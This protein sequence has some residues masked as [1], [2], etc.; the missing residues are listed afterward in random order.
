MQVPMGEIEVFLNNKSL[1]RNLDYIYK[2]PELYI[3]NKSHLDDPANQP[4]NVHIR[5]TG[6]CK[7][8]FTLNEVNDTGFIEHGVLS[9]DFSYDIRDDKVLRITMNGA[10]VTRDQL[11]FSEFHSGVSITDPLNGIPY[12]IKDVVVPMRGITTADTYSLRDA[13]MEIDKRVSEYLSLKIPQPNRPAVSAI[14]NRYEVYSPFISKILHDLLEGRLIIQDKIHTKQEV[15]D[16]CKEYEYLLAFDPSQEEQQVNDHYV[17]IHPHALDIVLG[18]PLNT[19]RFVD[20]V[21]R[22]Y[23]NNLVSLSP[24]VIIV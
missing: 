11:V 1:I 2:F 23:T 9:N 5:F 19:Y 17:I 22:I 18:V 3:I 6:F 20:N 10:L 8:D 24:F 12:Q 14:P 4:Q 13:S 15:I 7:Q 16:I 21:T